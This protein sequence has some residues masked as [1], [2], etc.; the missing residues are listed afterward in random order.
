[1]DHVYFDDSLPRL[2]GAVKEALGGEALAHGAVLRDATGRLAFFA[3]ESLDSGA[4]EALEARLREALGRYA[5]PDRVLADREDYGARSILDDSAALE[6]EVSGSAVRLVDRR[7]VGADWLRRP[8]GPAEGPPRFVFASLKGGVGRSTALG[9]MAAH[10]ARQGRRVLAV[11]LDLEAPGLGEFLLTPETLPPFGMLD[12]LVELNF[13]ALDRSFLDD[14]VAPSELADGRG[15]LDVLP[16]LGRRSHASP[17]EVLAKIARAYTEAITAEGEVLTLLDKVRL[18]IG[19]LSD[20]ARYDA[21]LVDARA[22]LHEST[23]ASLLGLGGEVLFFASDEPQTY[24]A[25]AALFAH[26]ARLAPPDQPVPEWVERLTVVQAKAPVT[27]DAREAFAGRWRELVA[28]HLVLPADAGP[29]TSLDATAGDEYVWDDTASD[30]EVL[31]RELSLFA[32]LT[33]LFDDRFRGF[34]PLARRD[35]VSEAVYGSTFSSLIAWFEA[36]VPGPGEAP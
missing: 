9:V 28:R 18:V 20:P 33:V 25:Y 4:R 29:G 21:V 13:G 6:L 34:E 30:D 26:L 16:A 32:P 31:P 27:P 10:L 14:L 7:I 24:P 36:A 22:G 35:Q 1:M 17:A 2:V 8:S 3:A 5:R 12:A 23:P 15:R 19:R 11:D